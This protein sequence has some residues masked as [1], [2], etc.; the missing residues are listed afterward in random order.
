MHF[1]YLDESGD[2]GSVNS[3][4]KH[5]II[6]GFS[7]HHG[8]WAAFDERLRRFRTRM[9][10]RFGYP[11]EAELHAAELLGASPSLHGVSRSDRLQIA[12]QLIYI[13]SH[14]TEIRAFAWVANKT[15]DGV[16]EAVACRAMGDLSVWT[17][18][19]RIGPRTPCRHAGFLVLHDATPS[20]PF[21]HVPRPGGLV[22]HPVGLSSRHDIMIQVADMIAY[23]VRQKIAPNRHAMANG[24]VTLCDK[25]AP[26]SL[27]WSGLA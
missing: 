19:G 13:L 22:G 20:Q 24:Y 9:F 8:D 27:G 5:Y 12:R 18:E 3:P 4:T 26:I 7:V 11:A 1:V 14:S 2:P 10:E 16:A 15:R 21:R 6:A 17:D 25:L 23:L